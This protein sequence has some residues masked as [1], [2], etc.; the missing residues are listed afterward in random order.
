[1][2]RLILSSTRKDRRLSAFGKNLMVTYS[3][4]DI[5][6]ILVILKL[7]VLFNFIYNASKLISVINI[8]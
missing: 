7:I 6:I 8:F 5:V 2:E 3:T 1:M 4:A